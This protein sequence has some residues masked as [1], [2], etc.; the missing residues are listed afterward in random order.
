M[1]D[2]TLHVAL[3]TPAYPPLPGGGERYAGALARGLAAAGTRV[4]VVTSAARTEA[5]FWSGIDERSDRDEEGVRVI[6]LPIRPMPGG[7]EGLLIWRKAMVTVSALPGDQSD[8]LSGMARRV[9]AIEG[10]DE[11]LNGLEDVD[12]IHAF[13]I[14][15]EQCLV[16]AHA[17]GYRK[18]IPLIVTPFLHLGV[19]GGDRVARNST[20]DH[21]LRILRQ[22]KRVL[23]L[24]GVEADGLKRLL[25]QPERIAVIGGGVDP[26]PE[27]FKSSPYFADDHPEARGNF[28]LYIGRQSFDKGALHAADA[29]R[30]LRR[31]GREIA[32]LLIGSS[33]PEFERYRRRL[34]PEERAAIRPLGVLN[35]RDK[36]AVISRAK[37]LMLPSRSDSFG[38]VLLEAWSHGIPV[39]AARAGGIP[40][41]VDDGA[42]GLLAP[43]ADCDGLA[44]AAE[45]IITDPLFAERLGQKGLEKVNA[46]YR[47]DV[48]VER[49]LGH[50][51][52]LIDAR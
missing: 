38:I 3:I 24:T 11:A 30:V 18:D 41:V 39:I 35:D 23:V 22:A 8:W 20:M 32:L 5:D 29:I 28:G 37:F 4:T 27:D 15:W 10:L 48:V 43:F 36:H 21:Q 40:G 47:W 45:R 2:S 25:F 33:T 50:Y 16:A 14:S 26:L 34:S 6:R 19:D 1:T 17:F 51:K 31:R 7:R 12:L 13:N 42:N 49:V 52:A 9:P 44:L 46:S